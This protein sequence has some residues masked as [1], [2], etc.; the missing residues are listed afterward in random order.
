VTGYPRQYGEYIL[1]EPIGAG[2]MSEVDLAHKCVDDASFVRFVAIKR[3]AHNNVADESFVRMFKDE[4]NIN[5]ELH[6]G[7]IVGVYGFGKQVDPATGREEYYM[8]MEYVPGLDL[9]GLQRAAHAMGHRLPLRF[10]FSVLHEVLQ[11]LQY[12]HTK[13]DTLGR[14]MNLVHRDINPRN[15][16]VSMR[17]EVKVIDFGVALAEDRLEKTQGRSLKG[18]FAYMSP[19]QIEGNVTLDGRTD[20]YAVGLMLHELVAGIGPFH[21]LTE[22]QIMHRIVMG[23]ITPLQAPPEFP[24]PDLL[25]QVHARALSRDRDQRYPD[26]RAFRKDIERAAELVGGLASQDERAALV[27][28][29]AP[30]QVDGIAARLK[31]YHESSQSVSRSVAIPQ[32]PPPPGEG[33]LGGANTSVFESDTQELPE[34][35]AV[36]DDPRPEHAPPRRGGLLL[37]AA[38]AAAGLVLVLG[39]GG[40]AILLNRLGAGAVD[41][42]VERASL[43]DLVDEPGSADAPGDPMDEIEIQP[44]TAS[45]EPARAPTGSGRDGGASAGAGAQPAA[46]SSRGAG[47]SASQPTTTGSVDAASAPV[48]PVEVSEPSEPPPAL[49]PEPDKEAAPVEEPPPAQEPTPA[50]VSEPAA[51]G[52]K[53]LLLVN[54]EPRSLPV[55][56]DGVSVGVTPYQSEHSV[57]S[58]QV[59]VQGPGGQVCDKQATVSTS[60]PVP[61][62]CRFSE[63]QGVSQDDDTRRRR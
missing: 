13:V 22:L 30:Q 31:R 17:G 52:P 41:Q 48:D 24:D 39:V 28:S 59:R 51:D 49:P 55:I 45:R 40:G 58:H 37:V 32:V 16:M 12:A 1:L 42:P 63:T 33:T 15:V 43:A 21:G 14:P 4:A 20:L 56:V 57:G 9:R 5:A 53:G 61:V 50:P 38:A 27:R 35:S 18:K 11:G 2:G 62:L 10:C 46:G 23:Q 47:T 36:I 25:L 60:R 29:L 26:A 3:V 54:S 6:H 44:A 34:Q 7:N 19:E 8:V